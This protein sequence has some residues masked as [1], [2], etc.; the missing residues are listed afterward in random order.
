MN[1]AELL[2]EGY[3]PSGK[4]DEEWELGEIGYH[5]YEDEIEGPG[6]RTITARYFE[7]LIGGRDHILL[8]RSRDL[9]LSV[10]KADRLEA[11]GEL[12]GLDP[13]DNPAGFRAYSLPRGVHMAKRTHMEQHEGYRSAGL[14]PVEM[15]AAFFARGHR[16]DANEQPV[17]LPGPP[18]DPEPEEGPKTGAC[19]TADDLAALRMQQSLKDV[20]DTREA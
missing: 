8:L 16:G 11:F 13:N 18:K 12:L 20:V 14:L 1:L 17:I 3:T 10:G 19:A 5:D 9:S 15:V 4:E 6:G 2:A 7:F